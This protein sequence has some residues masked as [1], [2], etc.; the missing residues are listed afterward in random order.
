ML[1]EIAVGDAYGCC[2]ENSDMEHVIKH[3][4]LLKY[5][6]EEIGL[7][8]PGNYTDDAQM[9]I[10]IAEAMIDMDFWWDRESLAN[11]FVEVFHRDPRRGYTGYFYTALLNSK[12]GKDLLSKI[13][14]TSDKSGAAMRSGCIGL[15]E[16]KNEVIDL[17]TIQAKVTHNSE[18]GIKSSV[19]ASLMVHYFEYDLG[20]KKD[21]VAWLN[22]EGFKG[23][24]HEGTSWKPG[25]RIRSYAWDCV[26]AAVYAIE[27]HNSL[28]DILKQVV[29]WSGDTDTAAA[30]AMAAACRSKEIAQNLPDVL[31]Q[32]LENGKYGRNY[33]VE[34]DAKL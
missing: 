10:A 24:L 4:D 20:D 5:H 18:I 30:I 3:N 14:G 29:A 16:D 6:N 34:L 21:L 19:L 9:S 7:V 11:K 1:L 23:L 31:I 25:E 2:F 12:D 26:E 13:G 33:L 22:G 17:S 8:P 15:L 32:N 27:R 28:A